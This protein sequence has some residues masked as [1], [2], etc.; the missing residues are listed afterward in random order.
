MNLNKSFTPGLSNKRDYCLTESDFLNDVTS[1]EEEEDTVNKSV[2]S[3]NNKSM[4]LL[5]QKSSMSLNT[6]QSKPNKVID[7]SYDDYEHAMN[8]AG[9]SQDIAEA[10]V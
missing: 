7:L 3:R 8:A 9:I 2:D 6:R 10:Y 5:G 1:S 4:F